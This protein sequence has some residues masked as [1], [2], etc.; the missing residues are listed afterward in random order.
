VESL[1]CAHAPRGA[2]HTPRPI[3]CRCRPR[4]LVGPSSKTAPIAGTSRHSLTK[5]HVARTCTLPPASPPR[6]ASRSAVAIAPCAATARQP[7]RR[8]RTGTPS[9]IARSL[10][11]HGRNFVRSGVPI[12]SPTHSNAAI[13]RYSAVRL[14]GRQ[15]RKRTSVGR[16]LSSSGWLSPALTA[17]RTSARQSAMNAVRPISIASASASGWGGAEARHAGVVRASCLR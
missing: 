7:M 5:S 16:R 8:P 10:G 2:G 6:A 4:L 13:M 1:N 15:P 9:R 14:P 17:L 12:R 11:C 3:C